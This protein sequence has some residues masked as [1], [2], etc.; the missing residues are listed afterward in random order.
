M[1]NSILIFVLTFIASIASFN[2]DAST[3]SIEK[4]NCCSEILACDCG[5]KDCASG[6]TTCETCPKCNKETKRSS[7]CENHSKAE[8]ASCCK[9]KEASACKEACEKN[10]SSKKKACK[11]CDKC[12]G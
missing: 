1:K 6:I 7:C 3:T 11:N 2:L 5:C 4:S 8:K 12:C 10:C 9:N